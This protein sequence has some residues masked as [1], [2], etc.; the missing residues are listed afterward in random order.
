M[1]IQLEGEIVVVIFSRNAY[2]IKDYPLIYHAYLASIAAVFHSLE[3]QVKE[4][5]GLIDFH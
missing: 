5:E 3:D 2:Q 1:N 4:Q